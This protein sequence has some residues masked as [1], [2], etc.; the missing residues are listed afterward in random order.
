MKYRRFIT[1]A[2]LVVIYTVGV[3]LWGAVV[4]A[5]GSGAGCG[6]HWPVCNGEIIHRPGIGCHDD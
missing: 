6:R 2:W 3:I 4:R 1:Y 5:T